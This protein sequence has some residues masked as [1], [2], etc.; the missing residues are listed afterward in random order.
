MMGYQPSFQ[1]KLFV[2]GFSLEKR[3]R[4]DHIL[5]KILKK[6]AFDLIYKELKDAYG[7]NWMRPIY[8]RVPDILR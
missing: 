4:K 3:I 2:M 7:K 8:W 6:I 1:H 5:R